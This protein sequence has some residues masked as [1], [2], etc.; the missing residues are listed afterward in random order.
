MACKLQTKDKEQAEQDADNLIHKVIL[1]GNM[2]MNL[3]EFYYIAY[4]VSL[5]IKC[6]VS[7]TEMLTLH[8]VWE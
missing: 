1:F 4:F 5:E 7:G 2:N 3:E 8:C 6:L